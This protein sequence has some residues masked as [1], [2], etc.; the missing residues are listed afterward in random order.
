MSIESGPKALR[1]PMRR[2]RVRRD[3]TAGVEDVVI[4]VAG[5]ADEVKAGSCRTDSDDVCDRSRMHGEGMRWQV[6]GGQAGTR[7]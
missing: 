3:G 1:A 2:I 6:S 5:G 7:G 4:G